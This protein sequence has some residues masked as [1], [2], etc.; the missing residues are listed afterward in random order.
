MTA[1]NNTTTPLPVLDIATLRREFVANHE[2]MDFILSPKNARGLGLVPAVGNGEVYAVTEL[3]D[4]CSGFP[5]IAH[6]SIPYGIIDSLMNWYAMAYL[7]K[8]GFT[9]SARIEY[10]S[11]I[12]IGD[13]YRFSVVWCSPS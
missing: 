8:T 9:R 10:F 13:V 11:P 12:H 7:G 2:W 6:G 1:A 4:S 5:G 3:A